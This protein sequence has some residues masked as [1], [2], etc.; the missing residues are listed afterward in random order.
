MKAIVDFIGAIGEMIMSG[1]N[2]V[3]S[4][5]QD[6]IYA[7][8]LFGK[9]IAQIPGYFSFLPSAALAVLGLMLAIALILFVV[10]RR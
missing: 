9:F 7:I 1:L 2:F 5:F 6:L 10:G 3:V 8:S 4:L